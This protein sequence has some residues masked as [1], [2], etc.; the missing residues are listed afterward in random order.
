MQLKHLNRIYVQNITICFAKVHGRNEYAFLQ[1]IGG[2]VLVKMS[3]IIL[4]EKKMKKMFQKMR[5]L[6][7]LKMRWNHFNDP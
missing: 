5:Y 1:H 3:I 2:I 6:L 7:P 4:R